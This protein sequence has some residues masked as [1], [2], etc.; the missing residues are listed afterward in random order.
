MKINDIYAFSYIKLD[1]K[2]IHNKI[3]RSHKCQI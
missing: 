1:I 3:I 2:N